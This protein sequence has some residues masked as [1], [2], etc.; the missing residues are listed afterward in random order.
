[1][2]LTAE[3]KKFLILM[4]GPDD[5]GEPRLVLDAERLTRELMQLG[6]V[7]FTSG[8]HDLTDAGEQV[9]GELTGEGMT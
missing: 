5:G 7:Q 1:M 4:G 2:Q 6:L 9:Y 3:Q 8:I